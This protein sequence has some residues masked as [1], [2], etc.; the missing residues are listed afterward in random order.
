MYF[1][2][3]ILNTTYT[4]TKNKEIINDLIGRPYS[5][6]ESIKMGGIGSKRMVI[7]EA[8]PNLDQYLNEVSGI[9]YANIEMR[10]NGII[11]YINKGLKNFTWI[12]PY[13]QLV[14]YKTNGVSIHAQGSFIHF[15]NNIT[16]KENTAFLKKLLN[17][18]V[19]FDE[20]YNF[21]DMYN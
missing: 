5:F 2:I 10:P 18:K 20:Q 13:Y 4:N 16:F 6:L 14:F 11:I 21:Q 15:K 19:Q 3:V 1:Y 7:E 17:V 12:I 8:S 9:N